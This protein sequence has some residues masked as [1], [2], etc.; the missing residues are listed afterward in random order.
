MERGP[1]LLMQVMKVCVLEAM[2]Q[3]GLQS[4]YIP[5]VYTLDDVQKGLEQQY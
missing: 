5:C 4:L 1:F 3:L 2:K